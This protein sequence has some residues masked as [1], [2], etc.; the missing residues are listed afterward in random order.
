MCPCMATIGLRFECSGRVLS[1]LLLLHC[2]T[3]TLL[4]LHC[5]VENYTRNSR[6]YVQQVITDIS[7]ISLHLSYPIVSYLPILPYPI[8]S[9]PILILSTSIFPL[10]PLPYRLDIFRPRPDMT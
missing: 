8:L 3:A 7:P 5:R 2:Y 9:Y 10:N 1:T 4:R 6:T